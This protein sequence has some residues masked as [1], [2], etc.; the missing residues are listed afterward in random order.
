MAERGTGLWVYRGFF[1]AFAAT[2]IFLKLLPL[3]P[4][5]GRLPGPDVLL[6]VALCWTIRR[7]KLLPVWLLAAVFLLS[8]LLLMHPPGLWTALTI[9]ACEFVRARRVP[10]RTAT[11]FI[12]W[13]LVAGV[14][15][16]M[17]VANT[18]ILSIFVAPQPAFG[19]TVIGMIL[20]VLAYPLV[21]ILAGRALGLVKTNEEEI[22]GER[23]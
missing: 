4:G 2:L 10:L 17:T 13:L 21:V 14:V 3:N 15:A 22:L 5:P 9:L 20:T 1:I 19:L 16:A 6:L 18:L 11:F 8:D 23:A 12:E 7:A